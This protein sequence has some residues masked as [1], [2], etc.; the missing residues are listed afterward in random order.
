MFTSLVA[1]WR[2][3][4]HIFENKGNF[5]VISNIDND[6]GNELL[7]FGNDNYYLARRTN[8]VHVFIQVFPMHTLYI[9]ASKLIHHTLLI[10][11]VGQNYINT[12]NIHLSDQ[13]Y[14]QSVHLAK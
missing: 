13:T 7:L 2:H 10:S 14:W 5:I 9:N 12:I 11:I 4:L 8:N 3:I 6:T 1:C